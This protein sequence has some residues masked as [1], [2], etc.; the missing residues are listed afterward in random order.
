MYLNRWL[1]FISERFHPMSHF[2]MILFFVLAH[3]G[4]YLTPPIKIY[5]NITIELLFLLFVSSIFFLKLRLYD[6]VKDFDYDAELH[7]NRPL[8][9]GL[10]GVKDIYYA[11]FFA[12]FLEIIIFSLLGTWP[13]IAIS[14]TIL[15][16]LFMFK[17]FFVAKWLRAH[18]TTYAISH[19]LV[20]VLFSFTLFSAISDMPFWQ[21]PR[22]FLYFSFASWFLFN[23]FE[24]GR[25]TF[26]SG[27][28]KKG[29][30][31]YSKIFSRAGAVILTVTMGAVSLFFLSLPL[32]PEIFFWLLIWYA[33]LIVTAILYLMFDVHF[34]AKIYRAITSLYIV[35]TYATIAIFQ[36]NFLLGG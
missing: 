3:Y 11:I 33:L 1:K 4:V 22:Q 20:I 2:S 31:S 25:K 36:F 34:V 26:S 23:I 16:S 12:I 17:E 7:P 29:I 27:E 35:L 15:Y 24:F 21:L 18:L 5:R 30:N 32:T 8:P 9:S 10:L 19:T 14:L 28:E 6:D 13:A